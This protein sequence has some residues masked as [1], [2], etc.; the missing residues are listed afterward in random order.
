MAKERTIVDKGTTVTEHVH[1]HIHHVIQP[2]IEKESTSSSLHV[3]DL[4]LTP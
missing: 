4:V 2:V 1:H 3:F